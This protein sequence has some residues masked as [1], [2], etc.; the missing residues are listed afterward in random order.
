MIGI[1]EQRISLSSA[2]NVDQVD[3]YLHVNYVRDDECTAEK[4]L[5]LL[6]HPAQERPKMDKATR[7]T[8]PDNAL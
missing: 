7:K 5:R 6:Y 4:Q 2:N 3:R 1:E 8:Q